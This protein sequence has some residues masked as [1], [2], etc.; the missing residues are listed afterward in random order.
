MTPSYSL[1]PNYCIHTYRRI[2]AISMFIP[3]CTQLSCRVRALFKVYIPTL[4]SPAPRTLDTDPKPCTDACIPL[5]KILLYSHLCIPELVGHACAVHAD[6]QTRGSVGVF[7]GREMGGQGGD[8]WTHTHAY[9]NT[10]GCSWRM[11]HA[12]VNI[13]FVFDNKGTAQC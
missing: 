10:R 2:W 3:G 12:R 4:T 13:F 11:R 1:R 6:E 8:T 5:I 7:R 9:V